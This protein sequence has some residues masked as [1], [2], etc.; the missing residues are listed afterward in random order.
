MKIIIESRQLNRMLR[1]YFES[2]QHDLDEIENNSV[3]QDRI[4]VPKRP[5]T[6]LARRR[7]IAP[8][9]WS[10]RESSIEMSYLTKMATF[11]ETR[12]TRKTAIAPK[13]QTTRSPALR[14][15]YSSPRQRHHAQGHQIQY[16]R[17]GGG[18]PG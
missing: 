13:R 6:A 12:T 3:G 16:Y 4:D 8:E 7:R 5:F 10:A 2:R 15:R 11:P 17:G 1:K 9:R 14:K 18:G